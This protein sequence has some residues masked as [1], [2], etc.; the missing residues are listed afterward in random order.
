G[1]HGTEDV[2]DV[3]EP[4]QR[5]LDVDTGGAEP[6][7][8]D[9]ELEALRPHLCGVGEPE[10]DERRTMHIRELERQATTPLVTHAHC[11]RRRLRG[12]EQPALGLKVVLHRPVQV[13]V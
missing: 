1:R 12:C 3:E 13:E 7:S 5:A 10:S 4:P 9:S 8:V 2:L 6:T 11:C